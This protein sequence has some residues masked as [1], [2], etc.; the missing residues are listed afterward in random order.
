MKLYYSN[1]SPYSRKVRLVIRLK[2]LE[3]QVEEVL[4]NPFGEGTA[5]NFALMEANPLGK[6]PTLLLDDGT[7]LFDSPVICH[8]LDNL[9]NNTLLIPADNKQRLN[10]L[11]WEAMTD[12]LT[13]ATYNIAIERKRPANEQ[14]STWINRWSSEIK[15]TL[16]YIESS[17]DEINPADKNSV[18]LTH[19]ALASALSY[20]EL[21]L[22]EA[23]YKSGEPEITIAPNTLAWYTTFKNSSAMKATQL[24]D[25]QKQ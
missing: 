18:T 17:L 1:T 16:L 5:N 12:G 24:I 22:P 14:S 21:R 23:L 13:D 15:R 19:L 7:G 9:S 11:R 20:L 25:L 10:V 3:S 2:G 8:Y 6:I 4:V